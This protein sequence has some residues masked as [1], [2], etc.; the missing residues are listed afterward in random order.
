MELELDDVDG[1]DVDGKMKSGFC[2]S[3]QEPV[4]VRVA[5]F[6]PKLHATFL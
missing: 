4:L 3:F 5:H 2:A 1:I 6:T